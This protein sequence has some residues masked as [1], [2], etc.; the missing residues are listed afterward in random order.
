MYKEFIKLG[1]D[2]YS[3]MKSQGT[4]VDNS[5]TGVDAIGSRNGYSD[6]DIDKWE[7]IK[8]MNDSSGKKI[9][10]PEVYVHGLGAN[11]IG[12]G[13]IGDCWFLSAL[14]VVAYTRPKLLESLIHKNCRTYR[15]DGLYVVRFYKMGYQEIVL[16]DDRFPVDRHNRSVF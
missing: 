1:N 8:N 6:Y 12:Q 13:Q 14:S 2:V 5:F 10:K 3:N 15:E 16:V 4:F 11:D 9:T 7:R